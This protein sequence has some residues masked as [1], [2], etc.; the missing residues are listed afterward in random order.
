MHVHALIPTCGIMFSFYVDPAESN[1]TQAFVFTDKPTDANII[2]LAFRGTE[3]FDTTDWCTDFD[4]AWFELGDWVGGL[5]IGF[6]EALGLVN[7]DK[8]WTMETLQENVLNKTPCASGLSRANMLKPRLNGDK[9]LAYDAITQDIEDLVQEN[10][11]AKFYV[12]GHSLGGALALTFTSILILMRCE[13]DNILEKLSGVYTFGQPRIGDR[14]FSKTL[15]NKMEDLN[16]DYYRIVYCN[17]MVCRVPFD[18]DVFQFK[19]AGHTCF[20]YNSMFEEEV[21]ID[22]SFL[23][24]IFEKTCIYQRTF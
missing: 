2:F 21:S 1:T 14:K 22:N 20:Y 23:I 11:N 4:F 13:G 17:D 8:K 3:P 19:H 12:S 5:H 15:D 6:L 24:Q 18:D 10:P 9:L 16:V 7:R